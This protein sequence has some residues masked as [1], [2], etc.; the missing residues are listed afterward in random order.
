MPIRIRMLV[1]YIPL[2]CVLMLPLLCF[3]CSST[4]TSGGSTADLR[5]EARG[6]FADDDSGVRP[7]SDAE[8]GAGEAVYA[9]R[10]MDV[11]EA[12]IRQ[13]EVAVAGVSAEV[14]PGV[15][16]IRPDPD[17]PPMI[18]YGRYAD[19][20][21]PRAREDA[22]RI[23]AIEVDG[24]LPFAGAVLVRESDP[25]PT[26]SRLARYDLRNAKNLFGDE[27]FY[28]LQIGVYG[29]ED[30]RAP[31]REDL[32]SFRESAEEAVEALR[33]AGDEAFFYHGNR[34]SMV[35]VGVFGPDDLDATV[36]PE[37]ESGRLR[38]VRAKHPHNLLNGLGVKEK[39]RGSKE[40]SMQ[41]SRLVVIPD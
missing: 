36:V 7:D 41:A 28:T 15:R 20:M 22:Q 39:R 5:D 33:R 25:K 21:S 18:V 13:P 37:I 27:A 38:A 32:Q 10:L 2:I 9:I 14:G 34:S 19:P 31:S 30:G 8:P 35:T 4:T 12:L 23:R 1:G 16:A 11:P 26:S 40:G 29:R 3:G 24:R 6:V 17:R